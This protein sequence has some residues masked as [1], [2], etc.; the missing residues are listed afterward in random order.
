MHLWNR[1]ARRHI[2]GADLRFPVGRCFEDMTT[3]PFLVLRAQSFYY[4]P[5]PCIRYYMREGSITGQLA[6]TRGSFDDR[7][8]DDVAV[9]LAGFADAARTAMPDMDDETRYCIGQ[10]WAKEFTKLWWRLISARFGRDSWRDIR[11][12]LRRYRALMEENAPV[13]F[14]ELNRAHLRRGK[15]GRWFVLSLCLLLAPAPDR[16]ARVEATV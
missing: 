3:M 16:P 6:R 14:A 4:D 12:K 13:A 11:A 5:T 15:P 8:N 9:S 1:I 10:F 2:W 7:M